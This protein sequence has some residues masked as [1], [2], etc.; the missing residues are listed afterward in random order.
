LTSLVD[1][2][3]LVYIPFVSPSINRARRITMDDWRH[4]AACRGTKDPELFFPPSDSGPG[5]QQTAEAKAVCG[6]CP[7]R[8]DCAEYAMGTGL[9]H[10]VFGGMTENERRGARAARRARA[11]H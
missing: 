5:A 3:N 7:V 1:E 9:D 11:A 8:S 2:I 6:N 10:G 4:H